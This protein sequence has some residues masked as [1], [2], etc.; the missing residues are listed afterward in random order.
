MASFP[1]LFPFE[2]FVCLEYGAVPSPARRASRSP[3]PK[4]RAPNP[5]PPAFGA[6]CM[7]ISSP[8]VGYDLERPGTSGQI[9]GPRCQIQDG[10]GRQLP[11]GE[12]GEIMVQGHPVTLGYEN[13]EEENAKN[14]IKGWFKT[15]DMGYMDD[16]NYLFVTAR[17]KEVIN[18]GV[19]PQ[20]SSSR[21]RRECPAEEK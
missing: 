13:N 16:D 20:W 21:S 8:P 5:R 14:F 19:P 1:A 11:N 2:T 4:C 3:R 18:R 7:P 10:D 9:V 15:G 12:V 17:S 6:Q